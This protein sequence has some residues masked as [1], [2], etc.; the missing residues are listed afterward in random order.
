MS[1]TAE[2]PLGLAVVLGAVNVPDH[3]RLVPRTGQ[4]QVGI[5]GVSS[6]GRDPA[7]V[8]LELAS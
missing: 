7:G 6:D 1:V 4:D 3:N 5:V 2:R 8:A